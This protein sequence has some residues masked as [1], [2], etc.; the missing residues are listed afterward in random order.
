MLG[1]WRRL[2]VALT[3]ARQKTI[4]VGTNAVAD[5]RHLL[6]YFNLYMHTKRIDSI[7]RIDSSDFRSTVDRNIKTDVADAIQKSTSQT[8]R[9]R[10]GIGLTPEEKK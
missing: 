10:K 9:S 4:V 3:R 1:D 6:C 2:N 7:V 5:V 8:K